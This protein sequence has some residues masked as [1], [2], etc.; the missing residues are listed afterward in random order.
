MMSVPM[1]QHFPADRFMTT[2]WSIVLG[3]AEHQSAENPRAMEELCQAYWFPLYAFVRRQ[4]WSPQDAEDLTQDFFARVLEKDTLANVGPEKGKFRTFLLVSLKRFLNNEYE[5]RKAVKRGGGRKAIAL[6][7]AEAENRYALAASE[8]GS[9]EQVFERRW[10]LA[11]LERSLK[12]LA[13]E[14]A[15]RGKEKLFN[16][17]K[18]YLAADRAAPTYAQLAQTIGGTEAAARVAVHR[19]RAR[20][21]V[22]VEEE[23]IATLN[24]PNQLPQEIE[25]LMDALAR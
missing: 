4:G 6:D 5:K 15:A 9:P 23:I 2:R 16:Q 18:E 8:K 19:L 20:Y 21:R 1:E 3:A 22:L 24:D 10:A 12:T 13:D 7:Q 17:L 25:H 11:V 14:F